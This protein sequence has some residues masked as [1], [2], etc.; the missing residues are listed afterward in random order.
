MSNPPAPES[1]TNMVQPPLS[2]QIASTAKSPSSS[3]VQATTAATENKPRLMILKMEVLN[4]KSYAVIVE[5]RF[6][7]L[8]NSYH[9]RSRRTTSDIARISCAQLWGV[10]GDH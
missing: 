5:S 1:T 2:P 8:T 3:P 9:C 10:K 7:I 6:M 4:F